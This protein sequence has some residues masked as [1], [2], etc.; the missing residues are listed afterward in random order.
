MA[1]AADNPPVVAAQT[2]NVGTMA[3]SRRGA[4]EEPGAARLGVGPC[5]MANAGEAEPELSTKAA[6]SLFRSWRR[7]IR[8]GVPDSSFT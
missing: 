2:L 8:F 4:E 1:T 3:S 6:P 5:G 7:G